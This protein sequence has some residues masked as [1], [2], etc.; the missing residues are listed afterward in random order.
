MIVS[1]VNLKP[2]STREK[3][4]EDDMLWIWIGLSKDHDDFFFG[5]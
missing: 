2:L 5:N 3:I 1:Q 4:I